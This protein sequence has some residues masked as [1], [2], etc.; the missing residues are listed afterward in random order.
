MRLAPIEITRKESD[1]YLWNTILAA[2]DQEETNLK[3]IFRYKNYLSDNNCVK[4]MN[5]EISINPAVIFI[6]EIIS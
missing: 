3:N 1:H 2:Y 6:Q 5:N 4:K